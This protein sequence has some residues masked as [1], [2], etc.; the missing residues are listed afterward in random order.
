MDRIERD[1]HRTM[2]DIERERA[3]INID[4]NLGQLEKELKEARK[5]VK[6][7]EKEVEKAENNRSR[8]QK[9]RHL[10]TLRQTEDEKRAKLETAKAA[11]AA[12]KEET[13]AAK[14]AQKEVDAAI[15]RE[16]QRARVFERTHQQ[17]MGAIR[18]AKSAKIMSCPSCSKTFFKTTG[19]GFSRQKRLTLY[20]CLSK[21]RVRMAPEVIPSASLW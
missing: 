9:R 1:F 16:E 11:A 10:E 15:K 19:Y 4:S 5:A 20:P 2:A 8:A 13:K 18:P 7:Y 3:S 12:S 14:L 6:D 21:A 17:Y